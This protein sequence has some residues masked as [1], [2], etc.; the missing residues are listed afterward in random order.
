VLLVTAHLHASDEAAAQDQ[1][2]DLGCT[3]GLPV[4]VPT[5]ERVEAALAG[6]PHLRP[7]DVVG[8]VPPRMGAADVRSI[9]VNAVMAGC[10][11]AHLPVVCAAV[12]AVCDP[13]FTLDVVQATTHNA[14]VLLVVNGSA[15]HADPAFAS[16]SGALGPG[17]RANATVGR[18]LRL[19]LINAGGGTPGEGDMSTLGQPAKFTCCVAE[20]EETSP[21][22]PLATAHGVT[23]GQSA[24]TAL[25]VE[26]PRQVMFVPVGDDA[27]RDA[28]RLIELLA[29]TVLT[30]GSLGAMGYGGSAAI[31]L[32]PLHAEVLAA[33][34]HD[35]ASIADAVHARAALVTDDVVRLHGFVRSPE[36]HGDQVHVLSSPEH[37]LVAVAGGPG[38]Y[39]AVFAGLADGVGEAVTVSW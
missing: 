24:V 31:L 6:A 5:P 9:A 26:G 27:G 36:R 30:P 8:V 37:L 20:A 7:D 16:G 10:R 12:R 29:R 17:P 1:L 35:R 22:P 28:D 11:P 38:T 13:R 33:A 14:A 25:A 19:V 23:P 2:S 32:S 21:F 15:R 34:G 18:A 3:D 4:V 39:S